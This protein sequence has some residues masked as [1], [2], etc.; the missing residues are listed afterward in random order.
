VLT[1]FNDIYENTKAVSDNAELLEYM[2]D[3]LITHLFQDTS[4]Y[5]TKLASAIVKS[6]VFDK[7]ATPFSIKRLIFVKRGDISR[8]T[9]LEEI[10]V[11]ELAELE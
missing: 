1:V 5:L 11:L 6:S 9:N 4:R 10:G 2:K 3:N 8:N 7:V